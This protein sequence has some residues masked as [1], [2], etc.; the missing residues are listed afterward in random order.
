M[1]RWINL[2]VLVLLS[3]VFGTSAN[4]VHHSRL[5][6]GN[7]V[8]GTAQP[9]TLEFIYEDK[10]LNATTVEIVLPDFTG[11]TPDIDEAETSCGASAPSAA[12]GSGSGSGYSV[13]ITIDGDQTEARGICKIT[14]T[15]VTLPT[16]IKESDLNTYKI[17]I[18]DVDKGSVSQSD[19]VVGIALSTGEGEEDRITFSTHAVNT[20]VDITYSFQYN[21]AFTKDSETIKLHLPYFQGDPLPK[22]TSV[23]GTTTFEFAL[24]G[25]PGTEGTTVIATVKDANLD[26]NTRCTI[27]II[28]MLTPLAGNNFAADYRKL[29][30]SFADDQTT[31]TTKVPIAV[32]D[33]IGVPSL[34]SVKSECRVG[35]VSTGDLKDCD[36]TASC[37]K[38]TTHGSF[39]KT[40]GTSCRT[41]DQ[42]RCDARVSAQTSVDVYFNPNGVPGIVT[43]GAFVEDGAP[44]F[45]QSTDPEP[46]RSHIS[47]LT[48]GSATNDLYSRN[49]AVVTSS[50]TYSD[51]VI[52]LNRLKSD[53]LYHVYCHGDDFKLSE[54]LDV[55]TLADTFLSGISLTVSTLTGKASPGTLTLKFTHGVQLAQGNTIEMKTDPWSLFGSDADAVCTAKSGGLPISV[56]QARGATTTLT[57]TVGDGS[58]AGNEIEISC[59]GNLA[60]NPAAGAEI[61][62]ASLIIKDGSTVLSS[63]Y[64]LVGYTTTA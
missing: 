54:F 60:S 49:S 16:A 18:D 22:T 26:A 28:G 61:N 25:G 41:T 39:Y 58:A 15:G 14:I 55:H 6:F 2:F 37:L 53:T 64:G 5:T 3:T 57:Y 1:K 50:E 13:V 51:H 33:S 40:Y 46:P 35:G 31:G 24:S 34:Y 19:A 52:T 8:K 21:R 9:I 42:V 47:G 62:I 59:T 38:C 30:A 20:P 4:F 43:C 44:A 32:T 23:C 11:N 29:K 17:K 36:A 45:D 27:I 48:M 10:I 12:K 7:G 56:Q 63:A